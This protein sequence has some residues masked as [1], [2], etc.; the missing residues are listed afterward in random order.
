MHPKSVPY[1]QL[2]KPKN[3][4]YKHR[5][6]YYRRILLNEITAKN[7]ALTDLKKQ[8]SKYEKTLL[9]N[10]TCLKRKCTCYSINMV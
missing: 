1:K 8:T 6:R 9:N 2:K 10:T 3:K 7:K 4:P 5:Y